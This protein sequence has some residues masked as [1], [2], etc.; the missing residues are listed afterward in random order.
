M[1][2]TVANREVLDKYRISTTAMKSVMFKS[3]FP[4]FLSVYDYDPFIPSSS[5]T[6][7]D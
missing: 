1:Y 3:L 2:D 6:F 5:R 7:Y 4:S